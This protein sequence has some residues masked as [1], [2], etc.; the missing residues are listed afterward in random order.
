M[1]VVVLSSRPLKPRLTTSPLERV[2]PWWRQEMVV[3]S[4]AAT[5]V[6]LGSAMAVTVVSDSVSRATVPVK[7][8][9]AVAEEPMVARL[10][11]DW[12]PAPRVPGREMEGLMLEVEDILGGGFQV[13]RVIRVILAGGVGRVTYNP[14]GGRV[15]R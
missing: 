8:E 3:P 7:A 9:T 2:M 12:E 15:V 5:P 6:V 13:I 1:A 4:M 14:S 11:V 10:P